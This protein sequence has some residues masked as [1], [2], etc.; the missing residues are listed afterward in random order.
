MPFRQALEPGVGTPAVD[1]VIREAFIDELQALVER[2]A[3]L[4]EIHGIDAD[5][6]VVA[7]VIAFVEFMAAGEF[8]SDR[9]PDQFE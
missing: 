6:F 2:P 4:C 5:L 8:G 1:I 9:V 3:A 7:G